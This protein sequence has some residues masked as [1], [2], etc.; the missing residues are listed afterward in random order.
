MYF[1]LS[2]EQE[3]G[4]TFKDSSFSIIFSPFLFFA[5]WQLGR[6]FN[7]E[8]IIDS[9]YSSISANICRWRGRPI[10][11]I[12]KVII[13]YSSL[14]YENHSNTRKKK[15]TYFALNDWSGSFVASEQCTAR[16]THTPTCCHL[17]DIAVA[18]DLTLPCQY[19]L[20][21]WHFYGG[22]VSSLQPRA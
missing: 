8:H 3:G 12:R 6:A 14:I 13:F 18:S 7:V 1:Q 16:H 20:R 21:R 2:N 15:C 22:R 9:L 11:H 19:L 4:N 10:A 17:S 5:L